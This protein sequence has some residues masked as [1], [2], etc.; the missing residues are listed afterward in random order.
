MLVYWYKFTILIGYVMAQTRELIKTLKTALKAQGKTYADVAV[1]LGLTDA[2]GS[3]A[4]VAREVV[5]AEKIVNYSRRENLA[6]RLVRRF[7]ATLGDAL[8]QGLSPSLQ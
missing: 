1:E 7:G 2:L 4:Y 8:V 6:E 5:Q 3:V